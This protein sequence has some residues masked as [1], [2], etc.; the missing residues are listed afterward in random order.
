MSTTGNAMARVRLG[1]IGSEAKGALTLI[2]RMI[3]RCCNPILRAA[4]ADRLWKKTR[5]RRMILFMVYMGSVLVVGTV[6]ATDTKADEKLVFQQ[7]GASRNASV[8]PFSIIVGAKSTE[9]TREI[10]YVNRKVFGDILSFVKES[11]SKV[12]QG[13]GLHNDTGRYY[14]SYSTGPTAKVIYM[15]SNNEM[16][17]VLGIVDHMFREN[18]ERTPAWIVAIEQSP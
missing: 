13:N 12:D 10:V 9:S 5:F 7:G 8:M 4:I 16:K 1:L 14:V 2:A 15:I 3:D 6:A 11:G 18:N 17:T